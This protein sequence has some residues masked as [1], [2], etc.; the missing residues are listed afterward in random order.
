MNVCIGLV[1]SLIFTWRRYKK[2]VCAG[3]GTDIFGRRF[4]QIRAWADG[5][6]RRCRQCLPPTWRT[7][8]GAAP[9]WWARLDQGSVGSRDVA[10]R[11]GA[12]EVDVSGAAGGVGRHALGVVGIAVGMGLVVVQPLDDAPRQR[13]GLSVAPGRT[14]HADFPLGGKDQGVEGIK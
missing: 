4:R 3:K 2:N 8:T 7:T 12:V 11:L 13:H 1:L 14:E 10:L 9:Y 5:F 6:C